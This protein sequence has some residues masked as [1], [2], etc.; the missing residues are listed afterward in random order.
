MSRKRKEAPGP[1]GFLVVDKP[2]GMTSHDVVDAARKL[3]GTRR[4]GHLGTLDP[5]ATGVLPLAIR[6]A[7]KLITFLEC[8]RKHY[9]GCLR[10]GVA[11]NTFDADGEVVRTWD[12]VLPDGEAVRRELARFVGYIEQVPPM[13]SA[14]KRDGVPLHRLARRGEEVER[15]ARKVRIEQIEVLGVDGSGVEFE[16]KCSPGTYVRSLA[17]D[18]GE[19][20]GCGAHLES[21]RRLESAPFRIESA[22]TLEELGA[23]ATGGHLA[24]RLMPGATVLGFPRIPLEGADLARIQVGNAIHLGAESPRGIGQRFSGVDGEGNLVA[25]LECRPGGLLQPLRVLRPVA[26]Q[27]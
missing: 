3:F 24:S 1:S 6:D 18:L 13:F 8:E 25:V 5:L 2:S 19:R 15:E 21:L 10:L 11:T 23:D 17:A 14:V 9:R 7:T 27:S 22:R 16:V 20:L 4:V 12:S 26:V